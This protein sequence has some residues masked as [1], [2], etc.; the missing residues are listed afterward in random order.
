MV[1]LNVV[2]IFLSIKA[3]KEDEVKQQI[4]NWTD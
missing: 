2:N 1:T 3:V 4:F